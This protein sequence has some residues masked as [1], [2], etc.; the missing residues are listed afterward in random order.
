MVFNYTESALQVLSN[1]LC[2][3]RLPIMKKWYN[4]DWFTSEILPVFNFLHRRSPTTWGTVAIC[5][6]TDPLAAH[7][8]RADKWPPCK[9]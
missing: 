1:A 8:M 9:N 2:H 5:I 3:L 4:L 7:M 6:S